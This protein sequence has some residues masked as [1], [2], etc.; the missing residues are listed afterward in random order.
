MPDFVPAQL[1]PGLQSYRG[2]LLQG[3]ADPTQGLCQDTR[4][5]AGGAGRSIIRGQL[6]GCPGILRARRLPSCGSIT[7]KWSIGAALTPAHPLQ[8]ESLQQ[9]LGGRLRRALLGTS[10]PR[11][12]LLV[13]SI[14]WAM[15][16]NMMPN[17]DGRR[18]LP[19]RRNSG[20]PTSENPQ[21]ANFGFRGFSEVG[22]NKKGA[23]SRGAPQ[24][25]TVPGK[26]RGKLY[27]GRQAWILVRSHTR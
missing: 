4:G 11:A 6:L 19:R 20:N 27:K 24:N 8:L 2:G 16:R 15:R 26:R 18:E 13:G 17:A 22:Q 10:F 1:L 9:L 25:G 7:M 12:C 21:N 23:P 14:L 3:Q 5:P